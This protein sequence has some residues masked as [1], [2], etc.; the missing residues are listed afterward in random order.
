MII[1]VQCGTKKGRERGELFEWERYSKWKHNLCCLVQLELWEGKGRG[2][3]S[4]FCNLT[5]IHLSIRTCKRNFGLEK[6]KKLLSNIYTKSNSFLSLFF[7]FSVPGGGGHSSTFLLPPPL[8][9]VHFYF[10][11]D[12]GKGLKIK[13]K[14]WSFGV[15]SN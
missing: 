2:R 15:P 13:A 12:K 8:Q 7:P 11:P 4:L 3:K 6:E 14:E 10:L 1:Y 9:P 5:K